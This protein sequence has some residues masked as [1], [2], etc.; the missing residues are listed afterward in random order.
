MNDTGHA[1]CTLNALAKQAWRTLQFRNFVFTLVRPSSNTAARMRRERLR[2]RIKPENQKKENMFSHIMIGSNDIERS[3][4]FYDAALGALGAGE[5]VRNTASSGHTRLFYRHAGSTFCLTEPINGDDAS[6]ANGGT[7]GFQ[8]SSPE[9]VHAFHD[10]A[11]ANGGTSVEDPPGLRE[12]SMG[13]M[14]LAY[15]LDPDGHKLCAI[16]RAK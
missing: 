4:R 9:Q 12:N 8:C 7:I 3:K 5:P 6:F 13:A 15:V 14:H 11:V 2:R 16:H 1:V 10:A